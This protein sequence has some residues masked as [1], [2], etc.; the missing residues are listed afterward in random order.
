MLD[1]VFRTTSTNNNVNFYELEALPIPSED[2]LNSADGQA[3][4]ALVERAEAGEDV[5]SQ[6]DEVVY[7]L[8]GLTAEEIALVER[9]FERSEKRSDAA[10]QRVSAGADEDDE[11][12]EEA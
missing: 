9:S 4:E 5:Q 2:V 1:W 8:Y 11:D 10:E 12:D 6:I 7:R 3:L